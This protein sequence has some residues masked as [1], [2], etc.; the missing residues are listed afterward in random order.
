MYR[1]IGYDYFVKYGNA[2]NDT[3]ESISEIVDFVCSFI[4]RH[5]SSPED[6]DIMNG[7]VSLLAG[8]RYQIVM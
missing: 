7:K 6:L 5:P 4:C 1:G 3:H 2:Y 8:Q